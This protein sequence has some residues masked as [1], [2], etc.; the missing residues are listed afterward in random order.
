[1]TGVLDK[2]H[3]DGLTYRVTLD[4]PLCISFDRF[5]AEM[6]KSN[7]LASGQSVA[8][9]EGW[10][11]HFHCYCRRRRPSRAAVLR[12]NGR[13]KGLPAEY[14]YSEN[15]PAAQRSRRSLG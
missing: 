8:T 3:P 12:R 10:L 15:G 4:A 13:A 6:A 9:S 11:S 2:G 5:K 7:G 1:M 14:T